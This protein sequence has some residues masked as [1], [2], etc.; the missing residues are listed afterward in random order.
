V[1]DEFHDKEHHLLYAALLARDA[2]PL[3]L[4]RC[5]QVTKAPLPYVFTCPPPNTKL[6]RLDNVMVLERDD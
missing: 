1:G 2:L 6:H 4:Y 3:A 5:T